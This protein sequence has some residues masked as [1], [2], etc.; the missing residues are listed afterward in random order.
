MNPENL[1]QLKLGELLREAVDFDP[2]GEWGFAEA[3]SD[4]AKISFIG[5]GDD[6]RI[7]V[8]GTGLKV[9]YAVAQVSIEAN[10]K[11]LVYW[12]IDQRT[13]SETRW[14][15]APC[16]EWITRFRQWFESIQ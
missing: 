11:R 5:A 9:A 14:E 13:P 3:V 16:E 8:Y 10:G 12:A 7:H 15:V 6:A 2:E 1:D 4:I